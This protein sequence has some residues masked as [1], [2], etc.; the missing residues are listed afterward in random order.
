MGKDRSDPG[1]H[2]W[3]TTPLV[4]GGNWDDHRQ[5]VR[6]VY[7]D[8]TT[9]TRAWYHMRS[10]M[11]TMRVASVMGRFRQV[12]HYGSLVIRDVIKRSVLI[13]KG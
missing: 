4:L 11:M 9:W 5:L 10:Y 8:I 7:D 2:A 6:F 3:L 1:E 13:G 12:C